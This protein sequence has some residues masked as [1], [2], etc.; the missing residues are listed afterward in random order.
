MGP[1][2][3]RASSTGSAAAG[4]RV[5]R[6]VIT[7]GWVLQRL[8]G[9][10]SLTPRHKHLLRLVRRRRQG[11]KP[12]HTLSRK[13]HVPIRQLLSAR[14]PVP[15]GLFS[16]YTTG[17]RQYE[18]T[19]P[20]IYGREPSSCPAFGASSQHGPVFR[21]RPTPSTATSL[22][23][24]CADRVWVLVPGHN[25]ADVSWAPSHFHGRDAAIAASTYDG[26]QRASAARTSAAELRAQLRYHRAGCTAWHEAKSDGNTMG[27]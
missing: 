17:L 16:L 26:L 1:S 12:A 25:G 3:I 9:S 2:A 20:A 14:P 10:Q 19:A 22:T 6:W 5:L 15:P 7:S 8:L 27:R 4:K 11:P 21:I 23:T 18:P 13:R 24:L